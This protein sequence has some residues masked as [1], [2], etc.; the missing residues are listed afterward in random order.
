M[1][2]LSRAM[3]FFFLLLL[4]S[5]IQAADLGDTLKIDIN[6]AL[7]EDLVKI[8][9][10][11]ESRAEELISLRPFSSLNDLIR[12]K[13]IGASRLGDIKEQGLAWVETDKIQLESGS[14]PE[15]LPESENISASIEPQTPNY[16]SGVIIN[17]ILPSPQ[18]ADETEEWIEIHN[19][20]D[21]EIDF[22]FW[23]I[24]DMIGSV[25]TYTFPQG[26][27]IEGKGYLLVLRPESKI[28]LNN[29][30]DV[31]N[32]IQPDGKTADSV[33]Y[34]KA[35]LGQS[36]SFLKGDWLW[37]E[38]LTPG[39][40]NIVIVESLGNESKE[41][42]NNIS[43]KTINPEPTADPKKMLAAV[44]EQIN[45]NFLPPLI[46]LII[47]SFSGVIILILKKKVKSN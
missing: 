23:K 19:K 17:E 30:G 14:K 4:S 25:K 21:F 29:D 40:D 41:E 5:Y 42:R 20:N 35:L 37:G 9:H 38:T 12:I 7:L 39:E 10:I 46:A 31:L 8:I 11:G 47:S 44:N 24:S 3:A 34:E 26:T 32:L 28:T 2:N 22:S 27:K 43:E 45:K 1:R 15:I 6:T 36:Y 16:P 13:G 18:G 33:G